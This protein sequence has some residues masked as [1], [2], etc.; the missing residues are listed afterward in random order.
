MPRMLVGLNLTALAGVLLA[1]SLVPAA[2]QN[3]HRATRELAA[4]RRPQIVIH[5]RHR[6]GPNATRHCV[7]WLAKRTWPNGQVVITP[8][9]RCWWEY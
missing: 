5:P 9:M 4:Q 2:A 3:T 6:L 7:A 1:A 8:Q